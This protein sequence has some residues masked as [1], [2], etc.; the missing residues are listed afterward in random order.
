METFAVNGLVFE[1]NDRGY[2]WCITPGKRMIVLRREDRDALRTE[3]A[4][5]NS[6]ALADWIRAR[7][8]IAE[9]EAPA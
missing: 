5:A 8:H 4:F 1:E 6:A 7:Q 2:F 3:P 9:M